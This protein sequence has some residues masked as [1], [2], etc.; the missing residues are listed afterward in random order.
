MGCDGMD[1][2]MDIYGHVIRDRIQRASPE[3]LGLVGLP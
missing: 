1:V 3:N 2:S